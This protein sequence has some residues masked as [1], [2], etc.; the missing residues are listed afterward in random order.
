MAFLYTLLLVVFYL[1]A[2]AKTHLSISKQKKM[3]FFTLSFLVLCITLREGWPDEGVYIIA[4]ERA[5]NF[6]DI[7]FNEK[8]FGY[9]EKGY[10]Y[11]ASLVKFI[12]NDSRF[13]LFSMGALSMHLLYKSLT[14]YCVLPL[15][16][17][18]DYIARFLLNRDFIQMRS[19]LAILLIILAI[20][21]I[22][23]RK[24]LKYFAVVFLAYQ[25]HTMAL[26]AV[27]L[28]FLYKLPLNKK[29][30]LISI[31]ATFV[32]SQTF[33]GAISGYVDSYSKDLSYSVYTRG[34]YKEETLGLAN[35]MIYFQLAI[36]LYFTFKEEAIKRLTPHYKLLQMAYLYSTLTLIMFS[37]YTALSGRTS[38]MF[39]TVEMFILP[40]IGQSISKKYRIIYYFVLGFVFIYFFVSKYQA[41][42]TMMEQG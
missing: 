36:L 9:A 35:P 32:L 6:F 19:S 34:G 15:L 42:I 26:I 23:K 38:T 25:I 14:K 17:L 18:C 8:P 41:A 10:F 30:V 21:N 3:L 37:N 24:P 39:A 27:P 11:L 7:T 2:I 29:I 13:Y 4:F 16:G 31:V 20:D 40:F 28:Y 12:Y 33:A 22:Y 1:I 5:P